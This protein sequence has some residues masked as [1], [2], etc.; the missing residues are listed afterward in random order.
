MTLYGR[1]L[2]NP[3]GSAYSILKRNTFEC[4]PLPKW[5]LSGN[6]FGSSYAGNV[7][8]ARRTAMNGFSK[9]AIAPH[10]MPLPIDLMFFNAKCDAGNNRVNLSWVTSSEINNSHFTVEFSTDGIHYN[11]IATIPGAE[12]STSVLQYS[13]S[14]NDI[15]CNECYYKLKQTDFNGDFTYSNP[16][17]VNCA[18]GYEFELIGFV[19]NPAK[20]DLFAFFT[21]NNDETV[22]ITVFDMTG[23]KVIATEYA[24]HYGHNKAVIDL[25]HLPEGVYYVKLANNEKTLSDKIVKQY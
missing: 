14:H 6:Y 10:T 5:G 11:D 3:G 12:N 13:Y 15:D 19:P 20:D 25:S 1:N 23:R 17:S 16:V 4:D 9:F 7:V 8:Y 21:D 2:S 22:Y 18:K 24:A